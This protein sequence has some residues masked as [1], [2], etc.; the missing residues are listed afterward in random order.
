[1][2]KIQVCSWCAQPAVWLSPWSGCAC[3]RHLAELQS[4][5]VG[6][7]GAIADLA[8]RHIRR[9]AV[10]EDWRIHPIA[11]FSDYANAL[12]LCQGAWR[13]SI[14]DRCLDITVYES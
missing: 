1:M 2:Q 6:D 10:Y 7:G 13:Y 11:I 4:A 12:A 14:H 3:E 5:W 9:W 8:D